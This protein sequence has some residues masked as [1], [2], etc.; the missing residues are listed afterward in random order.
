MSLI[1]NDNS[2]IKNLIEE[3]K[4]EVLII[5]HKFKLDKLYESIKKRNKQGIKTYIYTTAIPPFYQEQD[6]L[7]FPTRSR[8][9]INKVFDPHLKV[10]LIDRRLLFFGTGNFT[11]NAHNRAS[12][13]F[14]VTDNQKAIKSILKIAEKLHSGFNNEK[15][16]FSS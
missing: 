8:K 12:E 7:I 4:N 14:A 11:F 5:S 1:Y 13:I 15:N 10:M 3:S 16:P 2:I 9:L 6:N